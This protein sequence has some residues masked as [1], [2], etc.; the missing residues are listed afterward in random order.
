MP[1]VEKSSTAETLLI[2][3]GKAT[4]YDDKAHGHKR[5]P[6]PREPRKRGEVG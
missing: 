6:R 2:N 4:K 5:V 1:L 3:Y